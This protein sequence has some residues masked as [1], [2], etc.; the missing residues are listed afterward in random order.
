MAIVG[1]INPQAEAVNRARDDLRRL[2]LNGGVSK[3][4]IKKNLS[5]MERFI[6]ACIDWKINRTK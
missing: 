5:V 6:D 4:E 3:D 1:Q 2:M